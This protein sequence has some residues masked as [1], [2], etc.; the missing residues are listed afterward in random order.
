MVSLPVNIV[1]LICEWAGQED[2]DWYPFFSP[3]THNLSWK[4]NKHSRNWFKKET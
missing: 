2:I 1:N 4:V 3:K